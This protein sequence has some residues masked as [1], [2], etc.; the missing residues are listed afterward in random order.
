M[1]EVILA[2]FKRNLPS[3]DHL[4]VLKVLKI[5]GFRHVE[6]NINSKDHINIFSSEESNRTLQQHL[7]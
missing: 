3:Y 6:S 2:W 5:L 4:F 1:E 7:R